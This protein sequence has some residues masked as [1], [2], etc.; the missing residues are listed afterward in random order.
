MS[1]A[2]AEAAAKAGN[3]GQSTSTEGA[4]STGTSQIF[5]RVESLPSLFVG[6]HEAGTVRQGV[7][8]KEPYDR[9]SRFLDED[10]DG[11]AKAGDLKWWGDD[12]KPTKD[13]FDAAG[14]E[15]KPVMDTIIALSTPYKGEKGPDDNGNRAW[16]IGGKA[17]MDAIIAAIGEANVGAEE[18]VGMTLTVERLPKVKRAWQWKATLSR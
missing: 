7:I 17:A 18:M 1:D 6:S 13:R 9:Q 4:R 3:G 16:Y 10:E 14:K 8:T 12:N 11:N 5:G 15:R 2:F